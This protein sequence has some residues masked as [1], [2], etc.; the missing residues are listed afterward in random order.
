MWKQFTRMP[1]AGV[2]TAL[3]AAVLLAAGS[4]YTFAQP[5]P[6]KTA[7]RSAETGVL[8]VAVVPGSPAEKSGLSR[9]DVILAADGTEVNTAAELAA[10]VDKRK[11]GESVSLKVSHGDAVKTLS[12]TLAE[13]NGRPYAGIIPLPG[14][15]S[16]GGL[17]GP[18]MHGWLS[19]GRGAAIARVMPGGPADKAGLKAGELI[20]S[21]DGKRVGPNNDLAALIDAH[22]AGDSVTLQ[23]IG[24]DKASREVKVTLEESPSSKGNPYLGVAYEPAELYGRAEGEIPGVTAG[25][26]VRQVADDSPAA[27]AGVKPRDLIVA[28]EDVPVTSPRAVAKAVAA[29]K[30]GD[31]IA[32]TISRFAEDTETSVS[33]TLGEDPKKPG[34]GRPRQK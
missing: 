11:A 26:L 19:Q 31:T 25:V 21:V 13:Q 16:G 17:G 22:K 34:P 24:E 10:A 15:G 29:R 28:I 33:V 6:E 27:K 32:L 23:V 1:R 5:G 4:A 9:G 18:W 20:E 2:L 3:L 30:P 8:V 7:V 14:R 12:I